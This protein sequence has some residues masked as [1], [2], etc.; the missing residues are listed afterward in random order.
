M[1]GWL[2]CL[3][4]VAAACL[5]SLP[6][7]SP[8]QVV[9]PTTG[10]IAILAWRGP[11]AAHTSP[12]RYRQLAEA[13]FTHALTPFP[14]ADA[15]A[16]ALD[17]AAANDVRLVIGCPELAAEPERTAARVRGH[18]ALAGYDL[19]DEPSPAEFPALASLAR[20]LSAADP[21]A[22]CYVNLLP[23]YASPGQLGGGYER[24]VERF[25]DEVP[26]TMLS[27]DHYPI[28]TDGIRGDYFENLEIASQ[29]AASRGLPLWAF[30]LS[31]AHRPYVLPTAEHVRFQAFCNLAYG[32]KCIQYFTYWTPF[33]GQWDFHEGPIETD[34]TV[35]PT[36]AVVQSVNRRI[37]ELGPIFAE[38]APL[39]IGHL[40]DP[41]PRGTSPYEP[42]D[43][44]PTIRLVAG[45]VLV[46][47]MRGPDLDYCVVVNRDLE[48][49]ARLVFGAGAGRDHTDLTTPGVPKP[50]STGS[51]CDI[52]P[53]D[54][55][56]WGW[57][58]DSA[59]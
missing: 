31:V 34:G 6:R 7:P 30:V 42:R 10:R 23:T 28:T 48:Q 14:S 53:A 45:R 27:F 3:A 55:R 9:P 1:A 8:G 5:L 40:G 39:R 46:S 15:A 11:P 17:V 58:R 59:D 56:I 44:G 12:E 2:K 29:A 4:A 25:L 49:S 52:P 36:Y 33:P 26:V 57:H 24:Y 32:A 50:A 54:L 47:H 51:G 43:G 38:A 16:A 37:A 13:G 19:G 20:R 18:A 35:T 41:L 22:L 21:D